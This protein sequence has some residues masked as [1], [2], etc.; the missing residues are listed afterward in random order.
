MIT[1]Y[2]SPISFKIVVDRLPNVEF[3]TQRVQIPGLSMTP[4]QQVSPIHNI[5]RTPDRLEYPDLDLSFIVDENANNYEE[6]L[7]WM[8]G[9]GT[10]ETTE[11]RK[12]LQKSKYGETSDIS[13]I[14]ENSSRNPHL[15]FTFTECF[16]IALSGIQLDVTGGDVIY[17]ECN[18]SMRYTNMRFEKIS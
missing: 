12:A 16:P 3:F 2:L 6:I 14:I 9:M 15:K 8:E 10:P 13:I 18:V 11:S 7:R 17:P 1:N 4:P 5:Y